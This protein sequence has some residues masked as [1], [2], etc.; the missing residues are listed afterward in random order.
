MRIRERIFLKILFITYLVFISGCV[1]TIKNANSL[2]TKST[3]SRNKSISSYTGIESVVAIA[4]SKVDV[5]FPAYSGDA[6]QIAYVIRYSS[7]QIPVYI[8][9][10]VLKS[11]VYL[12]ANQEKVSSLKATISDLRTDTDYEFSVEVRDIVSGSES[13]NNVYKP[14]KTFTNLTARFTGIG[15]IANLPGVSGLNGIEVYWAEAE[16]RGTSISKNDIDPTSYEIT[17]LDGSTPGLAKTPADM[18]DTTLPA[19]IRKVYSVPAGTR[20]LPINGLRSFTKY[21]VQVRAVHYGKSLNAT[22][23]FYKVEENTNYLEII[24]YDPNKAPSI[25]DPASLSSSYPPGPQGLTSI[26]LAWKRASGVF[27]HYRVY[28]N[29]GDFTPTIGASC[30]IN[31]EIIDSTKNLHQIVGVTARQTYHLALVVC[32]DAACSSSVSYNQISH[33][34]APPVITSYA[35]IFSIDTAK[36]LATLDKLFLNVAVPD[37]NLGY[38]SGVDIFGCHSTTVAN[39]DPGNVSFLLSTT[40]GLSLDPSFDYTADSVIA[41]SGID[42]S[43][44]YPYCFYSRPFIYNDLSVKTYVDA[45]LSSTKCRVPEIKSPAFSGFDIDSTCE[46]LKWQVPSS[47]VLDGYEIYYRLKSSAYEASVP[48]TFA[49]ATYQRII[50]NSDISEF[51]TLQLPLVTGGAYDFGIRTIYRSAYGEDY[52]LRSSNVSVDKLIKCPLNN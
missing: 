2:S 43:S 45:P 15:D 44:M 14:V 42:P 18:N 21:Y 39:C 5:Y 33:L 48:L 23:M 30:T 51:S 9:G 11:V 28:Y 46:L 32:K 19:S 22:N 35:G 8:Q 6:D 49:D 40:T 3:T 29:I 26:N 13:T 52:W 47:G 41:I 38:I 50:I 36:N 24:T 4:D 20:S 17:V 16:V 7:Q 37:F 12:N 34:T 1:G 10:D 31:C 25:A 27:D